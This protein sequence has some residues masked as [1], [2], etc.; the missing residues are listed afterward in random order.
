[1]HDAKRL[2]ASRECAQRTSR[3]C[4]QRTSRECAQP[5]M[6]IFICVHPCPSVAKTLPSVA[7]NGRA[8]GVICG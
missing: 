2:L 5:T 4:A 8:I 3:E 7:A 1:M 6:M